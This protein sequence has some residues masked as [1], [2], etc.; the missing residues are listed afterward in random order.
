MKNIFKNKKLVL[1]LT[2]ILGI[3]LVVAAIGYYALFTVNV[4]VVQ[5]ISVTGTIGQSIDC[6]AP[7]EGTIKCISNKVVRIDNDADEN[8]TVTV[9]A[10]S[11]LDVSYVGVLELTKKNSD[12]EYIRDKIEL[13]YTVVGEDFE[14]SGVPEGYTLIYYKDAVYELEDRLENPQ[15]AITVTSGIG[16]LPQLNDANIHELANYCGEPDN[17]LHCKGAKLWIVDNNDLDDGALNWA[18]MFDGYYYET[19]LIY[20]FA[21]GDG[22]ITVPANSFIEFYPQVE[23]DQYADGGNCPIEITVA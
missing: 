17:Y 8:R 18:H 9:L 10:A 3:G 7:A 20:Y 1:P 23:V 22:E 6:E 4:N 16:S 15:P 19:D 21:N 13:T 12:W 14:F 11:D 2:A 5:P